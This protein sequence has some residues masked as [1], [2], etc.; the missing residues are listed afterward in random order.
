MASPIFTPLIVHNRAEIASVLADERRAQGLTLEAL[1]YRA[2][3]SDRYATKLEHGDT[4]SGKQGFHISPMAE[5]W[6]ASLD[7]TLVLCRPAQ[8][9][10]IGAVRAPVKVAA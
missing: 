2:G 9:E 4:K 6:L 5:V 1:D 3:F 8:A 10:A 7:L